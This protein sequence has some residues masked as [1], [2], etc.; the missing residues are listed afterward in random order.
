MKFNILILLI[1]AF[2]VNSTLSKAQNV[3]LYIVNDSVVVKLKDNK[4]EAIELNIRM[5]NNTSSAIIFRKQTGIL[6]VGSLSG[7]L[8]PNFCELSDYMGTF[9]KFVFCHYDKPLDEFN[10]IHGERAYFTKSGAIKY[11]KT[12]GFVNSRKLK[13]R[14]EREFRHQAKDINIVLDKNETLTYKMKIFLGN[15][16]FEKN[17]NYYLVIVYNNKVIDSLSQICLKSNR[18][19]IITK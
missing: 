6:D 12:N 13:R 19:K 16:K 3:N 18:M 15:Y 8:L 4:I 11:S 17:Q 5:E 2:I 10:I 1:L 14:L 7:E 9:R